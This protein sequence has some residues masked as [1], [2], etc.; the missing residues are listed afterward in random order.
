[1]SVL[2]DSPGELF[3]WRDDAYRAKILSSIPILDRRLSA[4]FPDCSLT[5]RRLPGSLVDP[6]GIE[7]QRTPGADGEQ[8]G[9][10]KKSV[11]MDI[12]SFSRHRG[13]DEIRQNA[14]AQFWN[15]STSELVL[16]SQSRP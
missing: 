12:K 13:K 7:P 16:M 5:T 3:L 15:E 9:F 4:D 8:M 11:M 2:W 6:N 14:E 1:V 10:V